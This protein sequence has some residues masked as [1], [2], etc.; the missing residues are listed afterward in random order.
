MDYGKHFQTKE[1]PQ[2]EP[3]PGKKMVKDSAGGYA[4]PVDD[5]ARLDR[6]LILGT[7]GGTYYIGERKLTIENAQAIVRCIEANGPEVV[8]RLVDISDRGRAPKNDP[9]LFVLAMCAGLGN[10]ETRAMALAALPKVA[11]IG[12]HLFKFAKYVQG[13]RGWG[14][15]LRNAVRHWYQDKPVD[16]LAYQAVKYQQREGWSHRDLLRLSHPQTDDPIRNAL[17]KW[18]VSGELE[19]PNRENFLKGLHGSKDIGY[20]LDIIFGMET[21]RKAEHVNEI[22][23]LIKLYN[24]PR[25]CVPTDWL[26][27][28]EVWAALLEKMPMT[29]MIRNL[30]NMGKVG[31]LEQGSFGTIDHIAGEITNEERLKKARIHPI[32]LLAALRI[33]AEGRG[34]LGKGDW[35]AVPLIVDALNEAFYKS[36]DNVQPTGKRLVIGLDVSSSMDWGGING[37]PYLTPRDG[38]CAMAMVTFRTE[39]HCAI[40]A[41]AHELRRLKISPG[42]RLDDVIHACREVPFGGTDCSL[43]IT[44]ALEKKI[45]A[46]A[47]VIYTDNETWAG[48][49]H[50]AQALEQYRRKMDIPAKLVVVG[51]ASNEFSI[52]DPNDGGMMD[53]VGFDTAAPMVIGD[54][55][56]DR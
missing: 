30:G 34:Y 19:Q 4:F 23:N 1:T 8:G 49:I 56:A 26:G 53:V 39:E 5:W 13:F 2:T 21:A 44:W 10:E 14:R 27:K 51:M 25:E 55:I 11:R 45:K 22:V 33:Y 20:P 6:F 36:F 18:I 29:A 48:K 38:A 37:M 42:Q 24:L 52:A 28:K 9:A 40:M 47:F 3:I 46:D 17:Y 31:L 12:T 32:S 7:E 54:F 50:P 35:D 15:G 43:P 16:R 41:F